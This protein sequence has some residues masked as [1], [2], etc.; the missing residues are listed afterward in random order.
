[1]AHQTSIESLPKDLCCAEILTRLDPES[2]YN[3]KRVSKSWY[4]IIKNRSFTQLYSEKRPKVTAFFFQSSDMYPEKL[5]FVSVYPNQE[6]ISDP[7]S[8]L[9]FLDSPAILQN[10]CNGLLLWLVG[11]SRIIVSNPLASR[12]L[13]IYWTFDFL[14]IFAYG[15]GFDP[16]VSDHFKF[17]VFVEETKGCFKVKAFAS[18]ELSWNDGRETQVVVNRASPYSCARGVY[19]NGVLYWELRDNSLLAYDVGNEVECVIRLPPVRKKTRNVEF[20][21]PGCLGVWKDKLCYC[22]VVGTVVHVWQTKQMPLARSGNWG[23]RHKINLC[24]VMRM[25]PEMK[26]RGSQALAFLNDCREILL[27]IKHGVIEFR[28]GDNSVRNMYKAR[29]YISRKNVDADD[30]IQPSMFFPF[31]QSL[32]LF[33][34]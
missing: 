17:V 8:C 21:E 27:S 33:N 19:L 34:L 24:G 20:R 12:C 3:C 9:G 1:M 4:E 6:S 26:F 29:R 32:A 2:L 14:G 22:R 30:Y 15:V 5:Q 25:Y 18:E 16:L 13:P 7:P 10:S 11:N 28:F 31:V 23:I